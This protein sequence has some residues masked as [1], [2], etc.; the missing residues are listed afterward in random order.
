MAGIHRTSASRIP[1]PPGGTGEHIRTNRPSKECPRTATKQGIKRL[2]ERHCGAYTRIVTPEKRFGP[3]GVHA[4]PSRCGAFTLIEL[5]VVVAIIAILAG[6]LLPGLARARERSKRIA[7]L[8]NLKGQ[9]LSFT[10]YADDFRG[11]Y[12]TADQETAWRLD[13]LYV[14]SSNQAAA[15]MSYGLN[16]GRMR[17]SESDF[18]TD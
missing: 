9:A 16:G 18:S 15:L 3:H 4:A 2:A 17:T 12:P 8:S 1:R 14:M 5:L 13:A 11:I 10:M 7:C 6:M